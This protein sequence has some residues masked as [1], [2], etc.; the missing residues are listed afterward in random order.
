MGLLKDIKDGVTGFLKDPI[1]GLLTGF[2]EKAFD[3]Y[4]AA[5]A[6]TDAFDRQLYMASNAYQLKR[7]D[8]EAA[9]YNPMLAVSG[10]GAQ[11][12]GVA[13]ARTDFGGGSGGQLKQAQA[14][15]V[16]ADSS[17]KEE[18][19][20]QILATIDNVVADTVVKRG[21]AT[22]VAQETKNLEAILEQIAQYTDESI[23]RQA[24]MQIANA[25]QHLE[26]TYREDLLR[27]M[28]RLRSSE[29]YLSE[30][31]Q[32]E[33]NQAAEMWNS[34]MGE[35]WKYIS[36]LIGAGKGLPLPRSMR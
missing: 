3:N 33:A 6:A 7:K 19:R 17:N 9:G 31:S 36:P 4:S 1:G 35:V 20:A 15:N 24:G 5:E 26:W 22:K 28:N 16:Q 25:I 14:E 13:V 30:M 2:G 23:T 12:P 11:F 29:A 8:L 21:T 34:A 27:A 32:A 10:P 18:M